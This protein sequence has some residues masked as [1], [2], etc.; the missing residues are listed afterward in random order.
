MLE[1]A[2]P[3]RTQ[4]SPL[5]QR[6]PPEI[7]DLVVQ[8]L[9][10]ELEERCS[11]T[12]LDAQ[13][14]PHGEGCIAQ[15]K[16][17]HNPTH[18][19]QQLA[20]IQTLRL[21]C[22]AWRTAVQYSSLRDLYLGEL[23]ALVPRLDT[24]AFGRQF[25]GVVEMHLD[26]LG[27]SEVPCAIVHMPCLKKLSLARN[28]LNC[29]PQWFSTLPLQVLNLS[30]YRRHYKGLGLLYSGKLS[31]WLAGPAASLPPSL[32]RLHLHDQPIRSIPECFRSLQQLHSLDLGDSL[33][34]PWALTRQVNPAA[35]PAWF[36]SMAQH[37]RDLR[38]DII[39]TADV[40]DVLRLFPLE[41]LHLENK[42]AA[43]NEAE[44]AMKLHRLLHGT[45][46]GA[47]L[48]E[49]VLDAWRL[50]EVPQCLRGLR[51]LRRL[52]VQY[53]FDL[54]TMPDW[55]AELPLQVLSIVHTRV[56]GLP[57]SFSGCGGLRAV[58]LMYT[59]F[60]HASDGVRLETRL[61]WG[62]MVAGLEQKL[63]AISLAQPQTRFYL[64]DSSCPDICDAWWSAA[65]GLVINGSHMTGSW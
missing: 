63:K 56:D 3:P 59:P 38:L 41:R 31:N 20:V 12:P 45:P 11:N 64:C 16:G 35:F 36:P 53:W 47:S 51:Q 29:L 57:A 30:G 65:S 14:Q 7:L 1:H 39:S 2:P 4:I 55:L 27:L 10:C 34:R 40:P 5:G 58:H 28:P 60:S 52:S 21:V 50:T 61:G 13:Q 46:L 23:P 26:S 6:L 48:C 24:V 49:L 8:H 17:F 37:L 54:C 62:K 15:R 44:A 33:L 18:L 19:R 22:R 43:L 25:A 42:S 32:K 9:L